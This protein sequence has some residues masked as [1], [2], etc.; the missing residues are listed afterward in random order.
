MCLCIRDC[1]FS[2][3][4]A[5][6]PVCLCWSPVARC[7]EQSQW[8]PLRTLCSSPAFPSDS[9]VTKSKSKNFFIHPPHV[10][11]TNDMLRKTL[12]FQIK[13]ND[14]RPCSVRSILT[15]QENKIIF[16]TLYRCE[17]N[18]F[19]ITEYLVQHTMSAYPSDH[20]STGPVHSFVTSGYIQPGLQYNV[21]KWNMKELLHH[22]VSLSRPVQM[23]FPV[24]VRSPFLI[25]F[26]FTCH[27]EC[28]VRGPVFLFPSECQHQGKCHIKDL[29]LHYNRF[30]APLV[31]P[32][33]VL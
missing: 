10:K 29:L 27:R 21:I 23:P 32:Q 6:N 25:S 4:A 15:L 33:G 18:Y 12:L 2:P 17:W 3:P 20:D 31:P 26:P 28:N 8:E 14:K 7:C 30:P 13:M 16:F 5:S 22:S 9:S 11:S 24:H 19:N 1:V